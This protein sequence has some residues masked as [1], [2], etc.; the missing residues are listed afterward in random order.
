MGELRPRD[1]GDFVRD[2]HG[3][4]PYPWQERLLREVLA[5]RRWPD[6]VDLPTGSGKTSL[7]DIAV[8]ALALAAQETH[9]TWTPRRIV[10]V[11][12]RRVVV[13]QAAQHANKLA[14]A[15]TARESQ[16][17]EGVTAALGRLGDGDNPLLTAELRGGMVTDDAWTRRPDQPAVLA[18]T[19]DQ[20]GSRLLF[21]GYGVSKGMRSVHA[22]LLGADCLYLLDE[23]HL[24]QPFNQTL[25]AMRRLQDVCGHEGLPPPVH[26]VEMSATASDT[27]NAF[28]SGEEPWVFRLDEADLEDPRSASL[29]K[30]LEAAKPT[31]LRR[32]TVKSDQA[33]ADL[34]FARAC[35]DMA[36]ELAKGHPH[37]RSV[38]VVV[39]RVSTARLVANLLDED[40]E[41]VLLT[42]RMRGLD[43][44]RLL[45][46]V[47][48]RIANG[49]IRDE[50]DGLLF[51]VATQCIEAGA[52]FDFDALVTECAPLDSLKQRFGRLDRSGALTARND[53]APAAVLVRSTD[54]AA[55]TEDPVYGIA[56]KATWEWLQE[57]DSVDF[58]VQALPDVEGDDLTRLLA[59]RLDAPVLMPTYLDLLSQTRPSPAVEPD[60]ALF[61]HGPRPAETDVNV[62]WRADITRGLLDAA[63]TEQDTRS[64]LCDIVAAC[65][66]APVE[67]LQVPIGSV[68]RWLEGH[69]DPGVY[70][71]ESQA[72]STTGSDPAWPL[73]RPVLR[74]LGDRSEV[75]LPES[76]RPG[77][78]VVVPSTDGGLS[79]HS[80]DPTGVEPV[81]D[82][83]H[84]AQVA[85]RGKAM[86]R[87]H[88]ELWADT[89]PA[90]PR[91]PEEGDDPIDV[92]HVV[93]DWLRDVSAVCGREE[94]DELT[95]TAVKH[96]RDSLTAPRRGVAITQLPF[97]TPTGDLKGSYWVIQARRPLARAGLTGSF[98]PE[99]SS[100]TAV[101]V[102]LSE[103]LEGV[104]DF[105]A[106]LAQRCGMPPDLAAD[107]RLA[108]R[109]HDIGK[110]DP[111]FQL[112][113]HGGDPVASATA[114]GLL[115]KS[116]VPSQDRAARE[117]ARRLAGYPRGYRHE[118][119]SL[120]LMGDS[121]ALVGE[122]NDWELVRHLVASHHGWCRP[123]APVVAEDEPVA[124]S[125]TTDGV[126]L[127]ASTAHGLEHLDS[128]VSDRF[129]ALTRKYGWYGL[130]WLETILRLADHRRSEEETRCG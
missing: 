82:L 95:Q 126:E 89:L 104:G 114:P 127:T 70:D 56:L 25:H 60:V 121:T 68:R 94:V 6:L 105:A 46:V 52:D 19:V 1:F 120:A 106:S 3:Y 17:L 129:W 69:A 91:P 55:K 24:S 32:V 22:G 21:R 85:Q 78:T 10:L 36:R 66:P 124:T 41:T 79:R 50:A 80:W 28:S 100:F 45:G 110:A 84:A 8:F 23:V 63:W 81:T 14:L 97:A 76:L 42:G 51:V 73:P 30:V 34:M 123:L 64:T 77:D 16:T 87:L 119:L 103:H 93:T 29:V 99:T 96:I 13:S 72:T 11:V 37:V 108:G 107:I 117:E 43:R 125:I 109:L 115:A 74:W 38:A 31:V 71:V 27:H 83:G 35:A 65:P 61:L 101:E 98:D 62:V 112:M 9:A 116:A 49:R 111:R 15:L 39:N 90:L 33:T 4:D 48:G 7:I 86:L 67:A 128:G 92:R 57:L 130:A 88:P 59:P 18:S 54:L 2:V 12:D 102:P 122:A 44:Q 118:L 47:G 75:V 5:K 26:V 53:T 58:G 113:A 20:I 40:A